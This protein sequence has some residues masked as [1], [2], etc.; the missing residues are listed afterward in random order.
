MDHQQKSLA[1]ITMESKKSLKIHARAD[2][3]I[4]KKI[5]EGLNDENR[6]KFD[7]SC[8]GPLLRMSKMRFH[9]QLFH[10]LLLIVDKLRS[11]NKLVFNLPQQ[12]LVFG[13][14]EFSLI[15]GLIFGPKAA[16]PLSS[17][18][19]EGHFKDKKKSLFIEDIETAFDRA[20]ED[21][22]D[23]LKLALL[24]FLYGVL[25][26]QHKKN[27]KIQMDFFHV[28]DSLTDFNKFCWGT[29]VF[30]FLVRDVLSNVSSPSEVSSNPQ[31]D[32]Q[33]RLNSS[34]ELNGFI[35][36]IQ[37][38]AFEAI[39]SI[40]KYCGVKYQ[41]EDDKVVIPRILQWDSTP[42][43]TFKQLEG[44][45][46]NQY[47]LQHNSDV[48]PRL[49][50]LDDE[51]SSISYQSALKWESD[52]YCLLKGVEVDEEGGCQ[53][54]HEGQGMEDHEAGPRANVD[55]A[56]HETNPA[57]N[58]SQDHVE[59]LAL[60]VE[61]LQTV[62]H[63]L[64]ERQNRIE[65]TQS[66]ILNM[67]TK[68]MNHLKMPVEVTTNQPKPSHKNDDHNDV[69][70]GV[71]S[72]GV[73]EDQPTR[74][75]PSTH[76]Q[77]TDHF[78]ATGS[79]NVKGHPSDDGNIMNVEDYVLR[80]NPHAKGKGVEGFKMIEYMDLTRG[81][82]ENVA[83]AKRNRKPSYT[84]K[85]PY[86]NPENHKRKRRPPVRFN[87]LETPESDTNSQYD[88]LHVLSKEKEKQVRDGLRDM[89]KKGAKIK[90]PLNYMKHVLVNAEWF[91]SIRSPRGL[92]NNEVF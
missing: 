29:I 79:A 91:E 28:V 31:T 59:Q 35:Y 7:E 67:L 70:Q 11:S 45:A 63:K 5:E 22:P 66:K 42:F 23:R 38:W 33:N 57:A 92:L 53:P 36:A 17:A 41:S 72:T 87:V 65:A 10:H 39:P 85:S 60:K 62:V 47:R 71:S 58:P 34:I 25:L 16:C 76:Q 77:Y 73:E 88:P 21:S 68:V 90:I 6:K 18:L 15:T 4:L 81:T 89:G 26:G 14:G 32:Q 86:T 44:I 37:C 19:Y 24:L 50:A 13:A 64:D 56:G 61:G 69:Y 75:S 83:K 82:D 12:E 8:F 43:S 74:N 55:E 30:D 49:L 52:N 78:I 20:S 3:S 84:I 2:L 9:G 27:K 40:G 54:P 80:S 48:H 51:I 1:L 46:F